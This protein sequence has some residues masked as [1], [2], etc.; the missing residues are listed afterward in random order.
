[1]RCTMKMQTKSVRCLFVFIT[2][3]FLIQSLPLFAA[4]ME[5]YC[6]MPPYVTTGINPNLLLTIDNSASQYDLEYV[7]TSATSTFCYDG[8]YKNSSTYVGYFDQNK[9]Y[10]S[11]GVTY[12]TDTTLNNTT[13]SQFTEVSCTFAGCTHKA[14]SGTDYLC[15][16]LAGTTPDTVT[17]FSAKGRFLNWLATSKMDIQK[18]VLTGGKYDSVNQ[19][20][21]GEGRGCV[22]SRF[23]RRCRMLTGLPGL[24]I[25]L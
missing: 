12:A 18:G 19:L 11:G 17:Q 13:F 14:T 23:V 6:S 25:R 4:S 24:L 2:F 20:L 22:G 1:M 8:S 9:C 10:T 3:L 15:L 7:D 16:T 5:D 21:I